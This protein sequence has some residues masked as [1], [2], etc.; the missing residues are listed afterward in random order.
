[1]GTRLLCHM[2]LF[3]QSNV[4]SRTWGKNSREDGMVFGKGNRAAI[5]QYLHAHAKQPYAKGH[6][7]QPIAQIKLLAPYAIGN[8]IGLLL[9][10]ILDL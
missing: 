8:V 9:L 7:F 1:M 10:G 3:V 5:G 4:F 2:W 6:F